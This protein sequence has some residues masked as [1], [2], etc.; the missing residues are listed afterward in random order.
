MAPGGGFAGMSGVASGK[1]A[2]LV[3]GPPGVELHTV[4]EELPSGAVGEMVP[5]VLT[6][7]GAAMVPNAPAGANVGAD[8]V[9]LATDVENVLVASV[10]VDTGPNGAG[11]TG[12]MEGDGSGGTPGD[13]V[14]GMVDP[15]RSDMNDVAGNEDSGTAG[16][17][18]VS[19]ASVD[20]LAGTADA[21]IGVDIDGVKPVVIPA[22]GDTG[23]SCTTGV[24][25][26]ICPTG[27]AQVT[28]VPGVVGS[29]ANGTGANVV[30]GVP[31]WVNAENGLG[32]LSAELTAA[33]GI[34]GRLMAVLP[35]V[36][37][38]ARQACAPTSRTIVVNSKRRIAIPRLRGNLAGPHLLHRAHRDLAA[39]RQVDHRIEDHLIA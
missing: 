22:T 27:L 16:A 35:M 36:D 12:A 39:I 15:G 2:P 21:V 17:M 5:I 19:A 14:A 25:G 13:G 7:I 18:V 32:P 26:A 11:T 6:A 1:A 38:C 10:G 34:A 31:G 37:I 30:S 3:G 28:A 4:V 8:V 33:P 24:P 29:D 20:A 9:V 23:V